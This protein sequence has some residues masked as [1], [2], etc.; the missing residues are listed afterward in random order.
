LN[1]PHTHP[2][3]AE[4]NYVTHGSL[5]TG[6]IPENGANFVFNEVG[7]NQATLFPQGSI[8]FEFNDHC[9]PVTFVAF[10]SDSFPGVSQVAQRFFGLPADVVAASLGI[11]PSEV[12][13][14]SKSIPDDIALALQ[15]C[16]KRCGINRANQPT[17]QLQKNVPGGPTSNSDSPPP[18]NSTSNNNPTTNKGNVKGNLDSGENGQNKGLIIGLIAAVG[19]MGLGY[20]ALAALAL[21]RRRRATKGTARGYVRTGENFAPG[22]MYD[23]EKYESPSERLRTPY[24]PPSGSH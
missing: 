15:E 21:F 17:E 8:H 12:E 6:M 23:S 3:S 10:F 4:F 5:V 11:D 22:G 18:T 1:T 13:E 20:V 14:I 9:E 24:D 19:V 16:T 2:R 7:T